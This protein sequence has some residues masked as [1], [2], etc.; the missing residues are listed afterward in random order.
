[1]EQQKAETAPYRVD[2]EKRKI[3]WV[4]DQG[5]S[6]AVADCKVLLSY[7]LSNSSVMMAWMNRS[8]APGC[9][10]DV[11]PGMDDIYPDCEPDDV[12]NLAV[13]AAEYV[14]AEAIY[15]TPS[16]QAWVM[17]GLWNP[18]PGG[19]EEQFSSGS[20]KGHVLQ[21][22]ESLLSYPDF[23]ERQVLI[24]NYA[25]S[26]LQMASHPYRETEFA[27]KL[28][29][30]ARRLRNLLVHDE[31]EAQDMGLLAVRAIWQASH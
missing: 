5:A 29:D 3:Y 31:Q 11:V 21:V 20:P 22:V 6:L 16:P 10:I 8:L 25:E 23:R 9:A 14:Q 15:R 24:D 13:R 7:A 18:R 30:T 2:L 4:D 28:Q 26:F 19:G 17:L 12:W 27:T 1:M